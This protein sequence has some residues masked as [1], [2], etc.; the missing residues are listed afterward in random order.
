M[1]YFQEQVYAIYL[2]DVTK[3]VSNHVLKMRNKIEH[4]KLKNIKYSNDN[5]AHEMRTPLSSIIALIGI[6][7][8]LNRSKRDFKRARSFYR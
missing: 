4:N 1:N 5:V 7:L 8:S 6:L 3:M 2:R